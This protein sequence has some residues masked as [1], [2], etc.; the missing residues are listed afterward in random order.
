[1]TERSERNRMSP[2]PGGLGLAGTPRVHGL[3]L[4]DAPALLSAEDGL[5]V[6]ATKQ[7]ATLTG[8][9]EPGALV[10]SKLADLVEREG[11]E[12]WLIGATG[13]TPV[14]LQTWPHPDDDALQVT[15]LVDVSDLTETGPDATGG[16]RDSEERYWLI[17]AQ[18]LA[19]VASWVYYPDTGAIYRSPL[20]AEFLGA[21]GADHADDVTAMIST[22]HPDDR[23]RAAQ[24]YADVLNA[25]EGEL[26]ETEL[27]NLHGTRIFLCTGRAEYDRAGQ[28]VRV[29]GTVQDVTEHRALERQ[30][31]DERRR[32]QD[33]Q[34]IARLGTWEVDP[35]TNV[36][37][38]SSMLYEILGQPVSS[39][40]TFDRYLDRVH[41]DDRE[42]V[43]QAWRPLI[44]HGEQVEIEHRYQRTPDSTRILRIHG[45]RIADADGRDL[46]VGTAQ[47]VTEQRAVVTRM[48]RSSQRF[49]DLVNITPVGI[50]LFDRTE[51][52]VNANEALCELLGY[53]LDQMRGLSI[54]D[55]THPDEPDP[56]LPAPDEPS[57]FRRRAPQRVMVRADGEPV[58]CELHTSSSVQDDGTEFWLVVF[59]DITERRRAAEAL[60]YQAT[61]DDLTGL[62][63]RTAVKDLLGRL[64]G[65]ADSPGIAVLFCDIDNFKRVNDSLGHDAGD[66]L[67]VALARRLEG[68]LPEGCTPAR[69]SGDEFVIICS[70]VEACGGVDHLATR[71]SALLRTA[72]PVHGQLVRVSSSIGAAVPNGSG[73]GGEDLLRFADAAMFEAK[74]RGTGKVSLASPALMAAADRQL[75]LEGQL[76]EAL[77]NDGLA[78]HYQPVVDAE[79]TVVSAEAL[80][81][82]PHPERGMLSPDAFLPVAEQGDLLRELDRWVLRTA[83]REAASWPVRNGRPVSIA[84]NL[85]G[86]VPGGPDFVDSVADIVAETGIAWDRVI[87]ELVET[88]LVDLPSRTRH[89]MGELVSR[90]VRFAVDDFGTG[91]SSLARLKDL[92]AQIIKV[93]RRFVAGVGGDAS[94]FAVAR[95]VVDMAYAMDR[96]CVAEGVEDATQ[97]RLLRGV[98]VESYQGWLFSGAVPAEKFREMLADGPLATP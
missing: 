19:K 44:E 93:D 91:Y 43:R 2:T 72:V 84:V 81:R 6:A 94:D 98:G 90:G 47:D 80:I 87:L 11:R 71:V 5:V 35:R 13:R 78:L 10:G 58:Y 16:P 17:D 36:M 50:G 37:R 86:L 42:W 52:L 97:F 82:W 48:E 22:T 60:R 79:G 75:H 32:L 26:L 57:G 83:L 31:R 51:R 38:L 70:D 76:R 46:L 49:S 24:F 7:A 39:T 12:T 3:S 4:P 92:P 45:T 20:L 9:D 40:G 15:L 28:I 23:D 56:S 34:R 29:Q 33:A 21:G 88:S 1:M 95:A 85:A 30:L 77:S 14:R 27:R 89:E 64:L 55:I 41:P 53:R 66:E 67:L 69:L 74:R 59:Q 63:N 65:R 8:H 25:A 61:H 68:G 73:A 62:P 54:R 96:Q 18:R